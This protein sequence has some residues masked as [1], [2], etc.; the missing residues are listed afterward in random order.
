MAQSKQTIRACDARA[1]KAE[2]LKGNGGGGVLFVHKLKCRCQIHVHIN[3]I[4]TVSLISRSE[5][6]KILRCSFV[7][8]ENKSENRSLRKNTSHGSDACMPYMLFTRPVLNALLLSVSHADRHF[9][10]PYKKKFTTKFISL[11]WTKNVLPT[12]QGRV[13]CTELIN[14]LKVNKVKDT[15]R[16]SRRRPC[17][18]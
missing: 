5:D 4:D 2:S 11:S 3:K 13:I 16:P 8:H 17:S 10:F 18:R 9:D 1:G 7:V 6:S 15:C 12:M 14:R